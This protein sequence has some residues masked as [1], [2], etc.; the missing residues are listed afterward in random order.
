MN[1]NHNPIVL[2]DRSATLVFPY[3]VKKILHPEIQDVGP[4]EFDIRR[5]E[6]HVLDGQKDRWT[7]GKTIYAYHEEHGMFE[8]DLG[9]RELQA[10]RAREVGFYRAYLK[11]LVPVAWKSGVL[12]E[13]GDSYVPFICERSGSDGVMLDWCWVGNGHFHTNG[14]AVRFGK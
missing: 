8:D 14:V 4:A 12:D 2:I 3:W 1:T 11:G 9:L 5:L 6:L 7:S 13:G 10:I